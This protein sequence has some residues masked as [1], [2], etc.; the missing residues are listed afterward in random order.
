MYCLCLRSQQLSNCDRL[1]GPESLQF[2]LSVSLQKSLPTPV[3]KGKDGLSY[4]TLKSVI[5]PAG[6]HSSLECHGGG[7]P[8]S[9]RQLSTPSS[10]HPL[11]MYNT[12]L[13]SALGSLFSEMRAPALFSHCLHV[14]GGPTHTHTWSCA[15]FVP[16]PILPL[17]PTQ[18]SLCS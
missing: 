17:P 2:L 15:A 3:L 1:Y 18:K 16:T 4:M 9:I 6:R 10:R 11:A 13:G 14:S 8:S 5:F 7:T 12:P